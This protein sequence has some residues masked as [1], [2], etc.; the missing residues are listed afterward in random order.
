M[1][2]RKTNLRLLIVLINLIFSLNALSQNKLKPYI[3]NLAKLKEVQHYQN[4]ILSLNKKNKAV[5]YI[6]DDVDDFINETTKCY[7]IKVGYDNELR[8]ECRYIFHVNVNNINEIYIDDINGEIVY[9]EVWRDRQ[10]KRKLKIE[11]KIFDKDGYTNLRKE[12]NVKSEIITKINTGTSIKVIDNT[13]DWW[14]IQTNDGK[15]GYV[16]KSRIVSK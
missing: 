11:Y 10:N 15:K 12:K 9:L 7:R 4:Y 13:G 8:W 16:H 1:N 5:S 14:F 6:V 3:E 2:V